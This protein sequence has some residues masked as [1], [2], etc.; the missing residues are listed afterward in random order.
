M[1]DAIALDA[2]E[3]DVDKIIEA[4]IN[5]DLGRIKTGRLNASEH[6]WISYIKDEVAHP[7]LNMWMQ[8]SIP[9][10]PRF[11]NVSGFRNY[12]QK[13]QLARLIM[14]RYIPVE[15][16]HRKQELSVLIRLSCCALSLFVVLGGIAIKRMNPS[17][18]LIASGC[19]SMGLAFGIASIFPMIKNLQDAKE[20]K[21]ALDQYIKILNGPDLATAKEIFLKNILEQHLRKQNC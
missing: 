15:D 10:V 21:K 17:D 5:F 6:G 4:E 7:D 16:L 19:I 3:I 8:E 13:Y 9:S 14:D 11:K 1:F 18:E 2:P 20:S 12:Q